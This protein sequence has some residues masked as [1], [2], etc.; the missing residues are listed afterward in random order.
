MDKRINGSVVSE[1]EQLC[2]FVIKDQIHT[3]PESALNK[4]VTSTNFH[5]EW[6][7]ID[8]ES[9]LSEDGV[10]SQLNSLSANHD[11]DESQPVNDMGGRL[12]CGNMQFSYHTSSDACSSSDTDI[13]CDQSQVGSPNVTNGGGISS[14]EYRLPIVGYEVMEERTRFTVF[15]I[16]VEHK[17]TGHSWF[18]F[19]RYTDFVRLHKKLKEAFPAVN[20]V[21]PP[22]K[23]LGSNFNPSFLDERLHGLQKFVQSVLAC[24]DISNSKHVRLFF[25]LDDP[26]GAY[27]S[28][29]ESRALCENLEEVVFQLQQQ[30][31][32]KD[33]E[34]ENLQEEVNTLRSQQETLLNA[35]RHHSK[36]SHIPNDESN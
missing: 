14:V 26:P 19:R 15:K 34:I 4:T 2:D 32:D 31:K 35:L 36:S 12:S 8:N 23:W 11:N 7:Q 33:S 30:L 3:K 22:K 16:Q 24:K 17:A 13:S 6:N 9:L 27:D 1:T 25:C 28:L 10:L 18:V 5:S 20:F 29:E 21:L